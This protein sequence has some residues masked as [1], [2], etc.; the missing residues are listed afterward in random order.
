MSDNNNDNLKNELISLPYE[1]MILKIEEDEKY[2]K[3]YQTNKRE[4]YTERLK[5]EYSCITSVQD[6]YLILKESKAY[7][8]LC[9]EKQINKDCIYI[10][11]YIRNGLEYMHENTHSKNFRLLYKIKLF[12]KLYE[13]YKYL[14]DEEVWWMVVME[15]INEYDKSDKWK[16]FYNNIG[17]KLLKIAEEEYNIKDPDEEQFFNEFNMDED[18]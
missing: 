12:T 9:V 4:I 10:D 14:E 2:K 18:F 16:N 15:I 6:L 17:V 7:N 3:E 11:E 1:K 8:K 5:K 13:C